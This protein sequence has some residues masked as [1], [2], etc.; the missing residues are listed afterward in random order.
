M[1][2]FFS[3]FTAHS[4]TTVHVHIREKH[5][6][7]S[8]KQNFQNKSS[9]MRFTPLALLAIVG[10]VKAQDDA[11]SSLYSA[12]ASILDDPAYS[13]ILTSALSEYSSL[14]AEA[15]TNTAL[16]AS[17]AQYTSDLGQYT[18][19]LSD[20]SSLLNS[21]TS[22]LGT[23]ASSIIASATSAIG[24]ASSRASSA[25]STSGSSSDAGAPAHVHVGA[26]GVVGAAFLGMAVLL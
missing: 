12:A 9:I 23:D 5:T 24:S 2:C 22:G 25:A 26:M 3:S 19:A 17:L 16:S 13:S 1:S 15:A 10:A 7:H 11:I 14:T 4:L 8:F 18:S 20:Y 6:L 21:A